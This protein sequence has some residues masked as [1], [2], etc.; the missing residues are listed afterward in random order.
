MSDRCLRLAVAV[1][2]ISAVAIAVAANENP[3]DPMTLLRK[4]LNPPV[5]YV[6]K[7]V[8]SAWRSPKG[9]TALLKELRLPDGRYRIEYLAP[10]NLLGT[11][12]VSDGKKRWRIAKGKAVWE[13]EVDEFSP[14][15]LDLLGKNY[16][17]AV[18]KSTTV[19][20]HKAWQV[21]IDPKVKGKPRYRFWLEARYGIILKGEVLDEKGEPAAFMSVTE[22]KFLNPHE[23]PKDMFSVPASRFGAKAA[24]QLTK[25]QA[26]SKWSVR[27]PD[28][29]PFG[30]DLERVEEVA[31]PKNSPALHAVYSD[32]LTKVSLFVL[33]SNLKPSLS[34]GRVSVVRKGLGK[35]VL[36]V[37]GGIDKSLLERIADSF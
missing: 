8:V 4:A 27:L 20:G 13:H 33:P 36:L 6:C 14:G 21:A 29:L 17:L 5:A 2:L 12:I 28:K 22:L 15:R 16:R 34:A 37:V 7:V 11:V 30:F 9:D 10:K 32:G 35:R 19:L 24:R 25:P 3:P 18:L 1:S 31:L 26:Q 23:V